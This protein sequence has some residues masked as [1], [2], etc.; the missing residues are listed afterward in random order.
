MTTVRFLDY[1]ATLF[2]VALDV[3]MMNWKCY[4]GRCPDFN[5]EPIKYEGIANHSIANNQ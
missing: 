5:P 3:R 2:H 4:G 1:L